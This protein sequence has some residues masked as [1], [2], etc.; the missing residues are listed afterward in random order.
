MSDASGKSGGSGEAV[1]SGKADGSGKADRPGPDWGATVR[2]APVALDLPGTAAALEWY[3]A[4]AWRWF[5][6][7]AAALCSTVVGAVFFTGWSVIPT[8]GGL[9]GALLLGGAVV[10]HRA[11]RMRRVLGTRPWTAHSSVALQRGMS[12]AAVVLGG[13]SAGELLPLTPH[14]TQ[15]RFPLLN[16]PAGVLW[17]CGDAR[18]GGVLAPPGGTELIWARPVQGRRARTLAAGPQAAG[19]HGR[20]APRQPQGAP[21][22]TAGPARATAAPAVAARSTAAGA[23]AP[24]RRRPWWRGTFRWVVVVGCLLMALATSWS[25]ASENDPLVDLTVT[26]DSTDGRCLVRWTDP[27]DGR[28]RTGPFHCEGPRGPV[29]G[30][31]T[32]FVVSYRPFKGDLYDSELRGTSAFTATDTAGLG[33]LALAAVGGVGGVT[34]LVVSARR[35]R[36]KRDAAL[37]GP[38]APT[39]RAVA[40]SGAG[41]DGWADGEAAD[42]AGDGAATRSPEDS[43]VDYAALAATAERQA[44]LRGP[45]TAKPRATGDVRSGQAVTWW[46]VPMLRRVAGIARASGLLGYT[47]VIAALCGFMGADAVP[48]APRAA[49]V[50]TGIMGCWSAWRMFRS[51]I[52]LARRMARAATAPESRTRRYVLLFDVND[53]DAGPLLMLFPAGAAGEEPDPGVVADG[54]DALPEGLLR[55]MPPGPDKCPWA[56]LPAATGTVELRGWLDEEPLVVAWIEGRAYW[57]QDPYQAIDRSDPEALEALAGLLPGPM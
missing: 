55:L 4:S 32:G 50:L 38:A 48:A 51:G 16:G 36:E 21:D 10:R 2:A 27:F 39:A 35:R 45:D 17:W 37:H 56:G 46:R 11:R 13:P 54:G 52:P 29:E 18:T 12:G 19:L 8:L 28:T 7:G 6:G 53:A 25:V 30:W 57:P 43:R 33:G 24:R 14:T 49:A 5:G 26:G 1:A 9:G 22:G 23:M 44:G 15:W 42:G 3:R 41:T 40:D 20:Q 47:V 31:K 34:R